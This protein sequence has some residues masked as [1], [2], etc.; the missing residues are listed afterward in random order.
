MSKA[1]QVLI[2]PCHRDDPARVQQGLSQA[3]YEPHI[4]CVTAFDAL[5]EQLDLA[6][7]DLLLAGHSLCESRLA[8]L[9][10]LA[11][12]KQPHLPVV[13]LGDASASSAAVAAVR[14][15]AH[16][17]LG[18]DELHRLALVLARCHRPCGGS[19][20][21]Q[22]SQDGI[23][24]KRRRIFDQSEEANYRS[25]FENSP[26]SLWVLDFSRLKACMDELQASGVTDFRT[27]LL[28]HPEVVRHCMP[29]VKVLDV[30][31]RAVQMYKASSKEKLLGSLDEVA[32]E[33]VF[34][35][36]RESLTAIAEGK[37]LYQI[38]TMNRTLTGEDLHV[39]LRWSVAPGHEQ[40][41]SRV[42]VSIIDITARRHV[43]QALRESQRMLATL[44]SNLPGMAFRC[45]NDRDWTMEFVSDG[46]VQLTGYQP[47]DL[48]GN[49]TIA[50]SQIMHPEDRE[51]VWNQIQAALHEQRPYQLT[52]RIHT[53]GGQLKW[54]WEQGRG[55]YAPD[56]EVLAL[57]GF[58]TDITD[59]KQ[60]EDALRQSEDRYRSL[61]ETM[62]QAVIYVDAEGRILSAN[63]AAERIL[64]LTVE[65]MRAEPLHI[66]RLDLIREDGSPM[67]GSARPTMLARSSGRRVT[68]IVM[69][70]INAR[71]GQRRWVSASAVPV[72]GPHEDRP[73]Q[74]YTVFEDIT[75][76]KQAQEA[77]RQSEEKYRRLVEESPLMICRWQ[78][79]TTL[80][81]VNS[82]Y[83]A[84]FGVEPRDLVGLRFLDFL[85]RKG[86]KRFREHIAKLRKERRTC[87]TEHEVRRVGG[88]I[89]WQRW[90][91][92]PLLDASGKLV[93][94]QSIG[95]DITER[96]RTEEALRE[97]EERFRRLAENAQDFIYRYRLGPPPQY[98]YAS[99]ALLKITGYTPE[100]LYARPGLLLE[101]VH[102]DDRGHLEAYLQDRIS[103]QDPVVL[104]W[105]HKNGTWVPIEL[106]NTPIYNAAEELVA[107]EGIGRDISERQHA[108][109]A[110]LERA[111]LRELS[112]RIISSQEEERRRLS[113]ELHDE[114]GQALT[115]IKI[116]TEL[117]TK[118]IP[119]NLIGLKQLASDTTQLTTGLISEMR[120]IAVALRPAVLEDLG[121]LPTLRWYTKSMEMRYGL[122]VKLISRGFKGRLEQSF[123]TTIYRI[124]QEAL[125][126]V[127]RHAEASH[128][129][130]KVACGKQGLDLVVSDDGKGMDVASIQRGTGLTGIRERAHLFHGTMSL[131]SQ[132]GVGTTLQIRFS[133]IPE[134]AS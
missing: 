100:E 87:L 74:I 88:E 79:D 18:Y 92:V 50:F 129:V 8:A 3:G 65:K 85:P 73:C 13:L 102:P 77:L 119:D 94:F 107:I 15:G 35:A 37:T 103:F 84:Y 115:A 42:T 28:E 134:A 124:V 31:Q 40:T 39:A 81:F 41:F 21:Q 29:L 30:N 83:A 72:F 105:R 82:T 106:R 20:R 57:E 71:T 118:R 128:V 111:S 14:A 45:R 6:R 120:R 23:D 68:G 4:T 16:D 69:G 123:E 80:T 67:P 66:P 95:E 48:V 114:A 132:A 44:M 17:F 59:G 58:T 25:L 22:G 78:S 12:A 75:E 101:E 108:E 76:L 24:P 51:S 131:E 36:I 26:I 99:P 55:V 97:S 9:I 98:D 64:G 11:R 10:D 52:Y 33:E 47:S 104:R 130:V 1:V 2:L 53:A 122:R 60:A 121:L 34:D 110:M 90:T 113:R 46:C 112:H 91:D 116:N 56:G 89:C 32:G 70:I 5:C 125:T 38:E 96:K 62:T 63:P 126:N 43:E 117:L 54:V 133:V 19:T 49:R 7:W 93:E 86:R 61:F 127:V 109:E 27:Y